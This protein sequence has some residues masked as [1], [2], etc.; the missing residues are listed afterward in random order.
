MK[1][2]LKS[3]YQ[4]LE[5]KTRAAGSRKERANYQ[6]KHAQSEKTLM[7][8][9]HSQYHSGL[10]FDTTF[11]KKLTKLAEANLKA[12]IKTPT[13]FGT[14]QQSKIYRLTGIVKYE[15]CQDAIIFGMESRIARTYGINHSK[16]GREEK[17]ADLCNEE[18]P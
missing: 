2:K 11:K 9:L 16:E 17:V 8:L 5:A 18:E 10:S 7:S 15:L 6:K 14:R 13:L 4:A 12:Y 3:V 1:K